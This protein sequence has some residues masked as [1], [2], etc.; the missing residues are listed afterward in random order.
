MTQDSPVF[1]ITQTQL[2]FIVPA[3]HEQT[4]TYYIENEIIIIYEKDVFQS[5]TQEALS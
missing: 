1:C 5:V 2:T 3:T 4:V